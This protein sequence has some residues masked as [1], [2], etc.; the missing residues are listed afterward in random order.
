MATEILAI[1]LH[2]DH[3]RVV[4]MHSALR[5]SELLSAQTYHL[6]EDEAPEEMLQRIAAE[7]GD[8]QSVITNAVVGKTSSRLLNFP[9]GDVRKVEQVLDFELEGQVP[10][11][12]DDS[13]RTW[14]VVR[15]TSDNTTVLAALAPKEDI[16]GRIAGLSLVELEPRAIVPGGMGLASFV[17]QGQ[18]T[19][20]AV[21][22]M[23]EKTSEIV[24]MHAG[25]PVQIRTLRS[26]ARSIDQAIAKAFSVD[27]VKA[28]FARRSEAQF[29]DASAP[30]AASRSEHE[31]Q[32]S[33]VLERGVAPLLRGLAATFKSLP[34][35]FAPSKLLLT[36]ELAD[37]P[38]LATYMA[39]KLGM[40]VQIVDMQQAL[41][42]V[43]T[44]LTV[45][46][47]HAVALGLALMLHRRGRQVPLNLRQGD[48]AYSADLNIYR[49]EIVRVAVGLVAVF[50][51]ALVG[52]GIR[53]GSL[54]AQEKQLDEGFCQATEKI[55]GQRVCDVTRAMAMLNQAPTEGGLILPAYSAAQIFEMMSKRIPQT[56]D[57]VFSQLDLRIDTTPDQPDRAS[58]KGEAADFDTIDKMVSVLK[59]DPCV[60]DVEI[61]Q[62]RKTRDSG[63]VEFK[64]AAKMKCP[65]GKLPGE[66]LAEVIDTSRPAETVTAGGGEEVKAGVVP[67]ASSLNKGAAAV[68]EPQK[69][70]DREMRERRE[71]QRKMLEDLRGR[72]APPGAGTNLGAKR[73][74]FQQIKRP[75]LPGPG[76]AGTELRRAPRR[77]LNPGLPAPAK[78]E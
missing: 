9:F 12:L 70:G 35:P 61:S 7:H 55:V 43:E 74:R 63:R 45:G 44:K 47:D 38:G 50:V 78:E 24:V 22:G 71:L 26:G 67:T 3:A 14:N 68:Q 31:R 29:L 8:A 66:G 19:S 49:S 54:N 42:G 23:G 46:H 17:P 37:V 30:A 27:L 60:S 51:L 39:R 11:D 75:D 77:N 16:A 58:G 18:A 33:D 10:H 72:A 40:D 1:D 59:A 48:F 76:P 15:R 6:G 41:E 53:L 36:G 32:L 20:T 62:R 5:R 65:A 21:L 34:S 56:V 28:K 2:D 69:V 25:Q 57:V 73:N 64:F 13:I 4:R 52:M